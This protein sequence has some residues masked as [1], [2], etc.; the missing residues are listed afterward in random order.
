MKIKSFIY[1]V[2]GIGL[3]MAA[4][5]KEPITNPSSQ[6]QST[7]VV[8]VIPDDI[9]NLMSEEM[10]AEFKAG[11][12]ETYLD[13]L[14]LRTSEG[15]WHPILLRTNYSIQSVPIG[16][17]SCNPGEFYPCF[18]PGAPSDPSGCLAE[19]VS[20][21]MLTVADGHWLTGSVHCEY[22]NI[23]CA[24]DFSGYGS[25]FYQT[26][27]SRLAVDAVTTPTDYDHYNNV[28]FHRI[29]QY[30]GVMSTGR[31]SGAMGWEKSIMFTRP[32][33]NPYNSPDGTGS[34][35]VI[36]YGWCYW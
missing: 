1:A 9:V 15:K 5:Q 22:T 12:G 17:T 29:G 8:P 35:S 6:T 27:T 31:Y 16:G 34:S 4:C 3:F 18:R 24:P 32:E 26:G 13:A 11:P 25:G 21:M 20:A 7:F 36:T 14:Q 19:L 28:T 10:I 30:N 33:N 23:F 2:L